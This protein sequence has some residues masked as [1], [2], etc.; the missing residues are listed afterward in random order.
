[1]NASPPA[2]AVEG[3]QKTYPNGTEA[4]RGVSLDIAE[5]DFFGLLGPNG[6]GKTTVIG[7]TTG[8]VTKTAGKVRAFGIDLDEAPPEF[9]EYLLNMLNMTE[10]EARELLAH[11]RKFIEKAAKKTAKFAA[12]VRANYPD[13]PR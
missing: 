13:L 12:V 3:L 4:L 8:L 7:V 6:A 10:P 1:M 2:L 11:A 5:G 9:K